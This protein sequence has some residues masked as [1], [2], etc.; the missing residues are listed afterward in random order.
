VEKEIFF[1]KWEARNHIQTWAR[2]YPLF[3]WG[4]LYHI[5][6]IN[7]HYQT[8]KFFKF[9]WILTNL[10]MKK[11]NQFSRTSTKILIILE[12]L[13]MVFFYFIFAFFIKK[14]YCDKQNPS[15]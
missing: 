14:I 4:Q 8:P 10:K 11:K 9:P 5:P 1:I 13:D 7:S 12:V 6:P 15:K 2:G 3:Y